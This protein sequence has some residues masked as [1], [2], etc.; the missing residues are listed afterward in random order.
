MILAGN[1]TTDALTSEYIGFA[2]AFSFMIMTDLVGNTLVILVIVGN[3]NM[4]TAMNYVLVNLAVADILVAIFTGI[5]FVVGPTFVHPDG[6]TGRCLCTFITGGTT[7][8]TATVA[9]IYS[10]VAI[11]IEAY[12]AAFHPF[13]RRAASSSGLRKT[14]F[15]IWLIALLWGLPLYISVR[16]VDELRTCAEQWS[17]SILP[18]IYSFGW[19]VVAGVIPIAVMS[20]LYFKVMLLRKNVLFIMDDFISLK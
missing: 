18:K 13:K 14:V 3:K 11:A 2:A 10:L 16:Y 8:W 5:K 1:Q 12:H 15:L 20:V 7:A 19:I 6:L 9:S 4:R 17:Y